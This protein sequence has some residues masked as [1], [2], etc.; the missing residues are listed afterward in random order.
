[1]ASI[2]IL[3]KNGDA[4]PVGLRLMQE[5]HIVKFYIKEPKA[6]PSLIRYKNPSQ[7]NDPKKMLDQFDLVLSD[8]AGLGNLCD[9]LK[10]KGKLVLG[11]GV[12]NDKLELDREY[13]QKVCKSLLKVNTPKSKTFDTEQEVMSYLE[14]TT[15]AQV[16]KPL[17]NAPVYLTLVSC[18]SENRTLKSFVKERGKELV[19]C[20]MQE[21]VD[22]IEISTEG[23]FN[24]HEWVKPFNHTFEKKR[25]MEEDKG[26]NTGCMG[27]VVF[28]TEG[29]K[30]TESLLIPLTS[31]LKKVN[32]LGPL[33]VNCIVDQEKAYFL[34]FTPRFGYDAIQALSE[35]LKE[36]LFDFLYNIATRQG[37]EVSYYKEYGI[38]VRLS[39]QPYPSKQDC[40]ELKGL[41]F[42][43][44]P[45][46][47]KKHFWFSDVMLNK[48]QD[49]V[50]AGVD[51]VLGCG[52]AR[53]ETVR[54]CKR[55]VYRTI[56]NIVLHQDV[57]YR[58]DIGEDVEQKISRLKEQGWLE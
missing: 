44:V 4:V 18:D 51:G 25:F 10:E 24:G 47:A 35:L 52:T 1:M 36:P 43:Q 57:Q 42:L 46:E 17:G 58:R 2:L 37:K 50:C 41:Q 32:Y 21:Q 39:V 8:M 23:W 28:L 38:A 22:G 29:D 15:S 3:S 6:K 27:N 19:P 9:E 45:D 14:S 56:K 5:G 13:G 26:P 16:I 33:D 12:F 34:E 7:V 40:D 54:E 48:E 30:L 31:L 20:L 53:G 49:E 11:G 55:R